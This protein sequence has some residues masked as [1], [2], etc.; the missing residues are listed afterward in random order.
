MEQNEEQKMIPYFCHEGDMARAERTIKRL[1]ILCILLIILLV[2]TNAGWIYFESQYEDT[3][4]TTQTVMQD[5]DTGNVMLSVWF[6]SLCVALCGALRSF[7]CIWP[8]MA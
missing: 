8:C 3:V 2:G 4:T 5:V 1:W 6:I 7:M